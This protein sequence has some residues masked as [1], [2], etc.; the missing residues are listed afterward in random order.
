MLCDNNYL[1]CTSVLTVAT[2]ERDMVFPAQVG[3]GYREKI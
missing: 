3:S 2:G 1:R